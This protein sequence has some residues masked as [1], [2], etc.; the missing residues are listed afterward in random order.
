MSLLDKIGDKSARVGVVGLGYVGLPLLTAFARAGYDA[1]GIDV[2]ARKVAAITSGR[3]YIPDISS[4]ELGGLVSRGLLHATADYGVVAGLDVVFICV[5]TPY[6]PA[7]APDIKPADLKFSLMP[8]GTYQAPVVGDPT[9]PGFYMVYNK[10]TKGN[11]F[12]RPHFHPNDRYIVVLQGTWWVGSGP[13]FDPAPG[14][15]A[16]V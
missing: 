1:T 16:S 4:D 10:W 14:S 9:K 2:D 12:S 6:T 8:N 3:S 11:H 7:K 15:S 13:K 5:Q